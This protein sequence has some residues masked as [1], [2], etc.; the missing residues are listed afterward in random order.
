MYSPKLRKCSRYLRYSPLGCRLT[1]YG[2]LDGLIQSSKTQL[3]WLGTCR[4]I[5]K[6]DLHYLQLH[7]LNASFPTAVRDLDVIL[8]HDFTL[9]GH[10]ELIETICRACVLSPALDAHYTPIAFS[11]VVCTLMH[12]FT[13]TR[14][15][16]VNTSVQR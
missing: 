9:S 2:L 15:N 3:V 8:G 6:A 11:K 14:L 12:V 10:D 16:S 7:V 1:A 5:Q 13:C 4:L